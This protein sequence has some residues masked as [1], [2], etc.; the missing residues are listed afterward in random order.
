M[1]LMAIFLGR[2]GRRDFASGGASVAL[3][4]SLPVSLD[5]KAQ[6][7]N[8]DM[9]QEWFKEALKVSDGL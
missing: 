3:V 2:S 9:L 6:Q 7:E 1:D 4:L 8:T 5:R